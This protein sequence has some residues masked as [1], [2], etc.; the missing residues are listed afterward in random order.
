MCRAGS[1]PSSTRTRHHG[2]LGVA[3][4]SADEAVMER[5]TQPGE[6][7]LAF[8]G[9]DLGE[10]RGPPSIRT[11]SN[12]VMLSTARRSG[13]RCSGSSSIVCGRVRDSGSQHSFL[14]QPNASAKQRFQHPAPALSS[15]R[16][17]IASCWRLA[18]VRPSTSITRSMIA[19]SPRRS[20][21]ST[22]TP[23]TVAVAPEET[24]A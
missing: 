3:G 2:V 12:E 18:I 1:A 4:V 19:R 5:V 6:V 17:T 13:R 20:K 9:R 7:Q 16:P 22:T 8:T 10:V 14:S 23:R 15:R 24:S 11:T 21:R